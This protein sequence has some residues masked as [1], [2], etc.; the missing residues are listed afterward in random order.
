MD[1]CRTKYLFGNKETSR[2]RRPTLFIGYFKTHID[3]SKT[4]L[5]GV[6][7]QKMGSPLIFTHTS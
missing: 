2:T 6:M 7:R 1:L 5:G 4:Q 3:A